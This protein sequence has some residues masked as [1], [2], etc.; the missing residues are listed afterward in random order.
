MV[1]AAINSRE[2][3]KNLWYDRENGRFFFIRS[4]R[5]GWT[6]M[7]AGC[8]TTGR[9]TIRLGNRGY[10]RSYLVWLAETGSFPP[11]GYDIDHINR[12]PLDDRFCNLRIT[13]RSQ[14][15]MNKNRQSNNTSGHRNIHQDKDGWFVVQ[16]QKKDYRTRIRCH[17]LEEAIEVRDKLIRELHGEFAGAYE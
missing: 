3:L 2:L 4:S 9:C 6:G 12:N 1:T 15:C 5:T 13:T 14:N 8:T 11:K 17:T 7:E 10:A 16:V